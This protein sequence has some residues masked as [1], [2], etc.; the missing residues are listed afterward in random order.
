MFALVI[1]RRNS[2]SGAAYAFDQRSA[3]SSWYSRNMGFLGVILLVFL[4]VHMKDFWFQYKFGDLPLDQNGHKDLYTIVIAAFGQWW[5]VLLNVAAFIALGYH[6][7]HGFFSAFK[8]I[9]VYNPRLSKFLYGLTM[10]LTVVLS[11]GF[12]YIPIFIY[13]KYHLE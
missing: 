4:I 9:G 11:A 2:K 1:S 13:I 12:I 10:L 6:L 7:A 8:S 3:S 5:Y